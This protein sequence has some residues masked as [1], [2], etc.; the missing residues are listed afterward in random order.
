VVEV[1]ANQTALLNNADPLISR[2]QAKIE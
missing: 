2:E 1:A